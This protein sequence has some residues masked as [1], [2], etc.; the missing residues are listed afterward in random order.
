[1]KSD[2]HHRGILIS[3]EI[4]EGKSKFTMETLSEVIINETIMLVSCRVYANGK[5]LYRIARNIR[6]LYT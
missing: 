4:I 3:V 5:A 2:V 6:S 1:M